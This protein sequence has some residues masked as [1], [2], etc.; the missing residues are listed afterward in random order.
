M[1]LFNLSIKYVRT[2][3]WNVRNENLNTNKNNWFKLFMKNRN[4][5]C[6][7]CCGRLKKQSCH[8]F[9]FIIVRCRNCIIENV[10]VTR[11]QIYFSKISHAHC[12]KYFSL[13]LRCLDA[14]MLS[15]LGR[16]RTVDIVL[17]KSCSFSSLF[18]C[19]RC[20]HHLV[21]IVRCDL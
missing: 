14:F 2:F 20:I 7:W 16:L 10:R 18:C 4:F 11:C 9:F 6:S 19:N 8:I 13:R 5:Y 17:S 1:N 3:R 21:V 12:V 15:T